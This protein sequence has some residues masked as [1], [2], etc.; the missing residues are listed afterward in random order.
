MRIGSSLGL[1]EFL[2]SYSKVENKHRLI[3]I[4]DIM[5]WRETLAVVQ[6]DNKFYYANSSKI[7]TVLVL[8]R[9]LVI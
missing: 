2:D 3:R 5:T 9:F 4:D 8:L 7:T 1:G 6:V